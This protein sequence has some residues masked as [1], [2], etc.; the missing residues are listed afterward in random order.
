[1]GIYDQQCKARWQGGNCKWQ[2][3][4]PGNLEDI[5]RLKVL[6]VTLKDLGCIPFSLMGVAG[7]D[8]NMA[9]SHLCFRK[10]VMPN[11]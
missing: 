6:F 8:G 7:G 4:R 5:R 11:M 1:M 2:E 3:M 9:E 10:T